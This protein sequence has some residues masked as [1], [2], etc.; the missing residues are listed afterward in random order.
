MKKDHEHGIIRVKEKRRKKAMVRIN[1]LA[2]FKA[3][4]VLEVIQG[5]RELGEIVA[6]NGINPNMLRNWKKEFAANAG[7]VFA[8]NRQAKEQQRREEELT[9]EK[10]QM[11]K[12][13]EQLTLERDF[14]KDSFRKAG[15]PIPKQVSGLITS[16]RYEDNASC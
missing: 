13:I 14:L 11:L 6:E 7:R 4:L 2:E 15:K 9:K 8:G 16:C 10:E 1:Y 5:E 12:T 3:K